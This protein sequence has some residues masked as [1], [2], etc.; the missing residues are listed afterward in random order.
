MKKFKT[1]EIQNS[2]DRINSLLEKMKKAKDL[3]F[4]YD[5][6]KTKSIDLRNIGIRDVKEYAV[7]HTESPAYY[8]SNV[9]VMV[10]DN[11]LS[12][13]NI[14]PTEK[15]GRRMETVNYYNL[16]INAFF[17]DF[18]AK[19]IDSSFT[20]YITGD[21]LSVKDQIGDETYEALEKWS[22]LCNR[23]SPFS[24][25]YDLERWFE[26]VRLAAKND[27]KLSSSELE[28]WLTEE[29]GWPSE[30]DEI[31]S[32]VANRYEYSIELIKYVTDKGIC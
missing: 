29:Q 26:F 10:R 17:Y 27:I 21:E 28:Q 3:V 23:T 7:F 18:I 11:Q 32:D 1:L 25:P 2:Q 13:A 20:V 30:L 31:L 8:K 6:E 19:F 22:S 5:E 24:H 9:F 12:V 15:Q 16:I 4:F 14:V